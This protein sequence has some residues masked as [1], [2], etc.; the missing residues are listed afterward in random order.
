MR[1]CASGHVF[2]SSN[3]ADWISVIPAPYGYASVVT[4]CPRSRAAWMCAR[5][6]RR[7][8]C[9]RSS[10]RARCGASRARL[11][12]RRSSSP[13]RQCHFSYGCARTRPPSAATR[14][15]RSISAIV[16]PGVYALPN[17]TA[18]AP[19]ASPFRR[20]ASISAICA[21]EAEPLPPTPA[22]KQRRARIAQHLHARLDVA[23]AH[24][25]VHDLAAI[26]RRVPLGDVAGADLELERGGHAVAHHQPVRFLLLPVLVQVDEAGG[27]DETRGVDDARAGE[28]RRRR[29]PPRDRRECRRCEPR[30]ASTP[31]P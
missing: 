8:S 9:R 10:S 13:I 25:V 4:S 11:P 6:T 20:I 30:R 22:G 31:G 1:T 18:T 7:G 5:G 21:S 29:S 24:A 19:S 28:W 26:A 16:A 17:P 12:R 15:M 3:S 2:Q 23:D 14:N 27:D